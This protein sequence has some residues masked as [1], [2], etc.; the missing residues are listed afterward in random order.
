MHTFLDFEV[1]LRPRVCT[2][3]IVNS[4]PENGKE[5]Q[6]TG[7][8]SREQQRAAENRNFF[9]FRATLR[10]R[11]CVAVLPPGTLPLMHNFLDFE[12]FLRPRVCTNPIV[13]S[14]P[15]NRKEQQRTGKSS[16]EQQRA[17][18]NRQEQ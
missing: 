8:S 5:Q 11:K 7:K 13:N 14:D 17:A 10:E 4:D 3:P 9:P 2:N 15:E 18:E 1:F 12:V 16:R 6:R